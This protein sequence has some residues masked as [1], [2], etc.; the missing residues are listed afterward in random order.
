M[1]DLVLSSSPTGR[2]RSAVLHSFGRTAAG[3]ARESGDSGLHFHRTGE[4][5]IVFKMHML[6]KV[7]F[8]L[9]ENS[10]Q[11]FEADA[12]IAGS[13]IVRGQTANLSN[14]LPSCIV[15]LHHRVNGVSHG[16]KKGRLWRLMPIGCPLQRFYV[17]KENLL[18]L[19][20]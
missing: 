10:V 13:R 15:F 7:C 14:K 17:R 5:N 6:V 1:M 18:F 4:K 20:H 12:R 19:L 3:D 16:L 11:G 8:E 9:L 2:L